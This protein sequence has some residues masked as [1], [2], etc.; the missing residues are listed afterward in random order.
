MGKGVVIMSSFIKGL[1]GKGDNGIHAWACMWAKVDWPLLIQERGEG[2]WTSTHNPRETL[3]CNA[4]TTTFL[5]GLLFWPDLLRERQVE[6]FRSLIWLKDLCQR[7]VP[8]LSM[9]VTNALSLHFLMHSKVKD[10]A[11]SWKAQR[12]WVREMTMT[13]EELDFS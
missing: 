11:G 2:L 1:T 8:V 6:I 13:S 10:L 5:Q 3:T 12:G 9:C 7:L 4:V